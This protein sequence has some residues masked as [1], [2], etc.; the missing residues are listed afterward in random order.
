[1]CPCFCIC[2]CISQATPFVFLEQAP[3][4]L[5]PLATLGTASVTEK[6][7]LTLAQRTKAI[8]SNHLH[9]NHN[10]DDIMTD[11]AVRLVRSLRS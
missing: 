5:W 6:T 8:I 3:L 9:H 7:L 2:I 4:Y 1:M 11:P 10:Y